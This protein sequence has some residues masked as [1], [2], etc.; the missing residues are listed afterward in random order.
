MKNDRIDFND[1]NSNTSP[2]PS[3]DSVLQARLSRRG[4]LRGSVG[5]MGTAMLGGLGVAACGGG[6]DDAVAA[7]PAAPVARRR[8]KP[9]RHRDGARRL[10]RQRPLCAG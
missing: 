4:L 1:E 9:A 8:Q 10:H 7:A 3:F 5:T 2:N 6:S